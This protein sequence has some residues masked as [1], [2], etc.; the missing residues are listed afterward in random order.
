MPGIFHQPCQPRPIHCATRCPTR[1]S[2]L[3]TQ[4]A[5]DLLHVSRPYLIRLLEEGKI[6]FRKVGTRRRVLFSDLMAF[7][8]REAVHRRQV[9]NDLTTEAE[10]L[11]LGY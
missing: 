9:L 10:D 5:A 3:T 6:P 8:E 2:G 11:D 7:K 4:E 1:A